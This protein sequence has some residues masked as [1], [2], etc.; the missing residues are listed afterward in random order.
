MT[1]RDAGIAAAL[2]LTVSGI[3]LA[4]AWLFV[5][6]GRAGDQAQRQDDRVAALTGAV[7][8]AD[9]RAARAESARGDALTRATAAEARASAATAEVTHLRARVEQLEAAAEAASRREPGS[10]SGSAPAPAPAPV[11]EVVTPSAPERPE[12]P[13]VVASLL[14]VTTRGRGRVRVSDA[15]ELDLVHVPPGTGSVG[16]SPSALP[17]AERAARALLPAAQFGAP[18]VEV[19]LEEGFLILAGEVT[20]AQYL[21]VLAAGGVDMTDRRR[22]EGY[23]AHLEPRRD[24]WENAPV[25]CVSWADAVEFCDVL[26][27]LLSVPVRLPSEVEWELAAAGLGPAPRRFP[28]GPGAPAL[29]SGGRGP[30]VSDRTAEGVADLALG[31]HEWCV[32]AWQPRRWA[33]VGGVLRHRPSEVVVPV[34]QASDAMACRGGSAATRSLL[35]VECAWR[36]GRLAGTRGPTLGFRIVLPAPR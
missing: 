21:H 7:E 13:P 17:A 6:L 34:A 30:E 33:Q 5:L 32:D 36:Q 25:R 16:S 28:W 31:V 3:G 8:A 11:P 18:R 20:N 19:V 23:L 14:E 26:G 12:P 22:R 24:G 10:L 29:P 1:R 9:R 15:L 4:V 2:V 27:R 35:Q